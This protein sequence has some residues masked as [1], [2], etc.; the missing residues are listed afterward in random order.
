MPPKKSPS[1]TS[2]T[3]NTSSI[4]SFFKRTAST[5]NHDH[6]KHDGNGSSADPVVISDGED[7][8]VSKRRKVSAPRPTLREL[9]NA[10]A[11]KDGS[12]DG[13][14]D[15]QAVER[16]APP[17]RSLSI[18]TQRVFKPSD[19]PD[20]GRQA[21]LNGVQPL[22][23]VEPNGEV[24]EEPDEGMGMGEEGGEAEDSDDHEPDS[25]GDSDEI[26][27]MVCG[28]S[29]PQAE[30]ETHIN[31]CL[32]AQPAAKLLPEKRKMDPKRNRD[33]GAKTNG[34]AK[35]KR[36]GDK[37]PP[38]DDDFMIV[39]SQPKLNGTTDN[40]LAQKRKSPNGEARSQPI[41]SIS[42]S[43]PRSPSPP[44][45]GPVPDGKGG[46]G[47]NAFSLLMSG[48]KEKELWAD[49]DEPKRIKNRRAAP[50]YKVLTGMPIAVDAFCYGAV[51]GVN[52]Y[53]LTYIIVVQ[54]N[55]RHAHSDHYTNLSKSWRHGP[56]YCS[57]TTANLIILKL[58]VEPQ[59]VVSC[60]LT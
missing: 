23:I 19:P 13:D 26:A 9:S 2:S 29:L 10:T 17:L 14:G 55:N 27:C 43:I 37:P 7:E 59:W 49:V 57:Y 34:D 42:H 51:P 50:F 8:P 1:R 15:I 21:P 40:T 31:A 39:E 20:L 58:G 53:F 33:I 32:D 38:V 24:W 35:S 48:H 52:A 16:P 46:K 41:T 18:N 3:N 12:G 54:A 44:G 47:A 4:L 11:G 30:A 25:E 36:A 45:I 60:D 22:E 6:E 28:K 56:I 5:E